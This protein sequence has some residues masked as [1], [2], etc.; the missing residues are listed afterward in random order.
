M[1]KFFLILVGVI[2][3][4]SIAHA[5]DINVWRQST[6]N[7]ILKRGVL[8]VGLETG[9]MPFEMRSKTGS[10][11]GFDVDVAKL[12][13]KNMGVKLKLI[14]TAWDGII[15]ALMTDKFDIIMS[16]MTM[17][18]VTHEMGFAKKAA[19]RIAFVDKGKITETATPDD[20]LNNDTHPQLRQFLDKIN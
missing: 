5:S 3:I 12:M 10:I 2:L 7:Q 20:I 14:N 4:G 18:V 15:P 6:L 16:G 19:D 17:I 1:K 11:I 8:R 13:A 9:Y